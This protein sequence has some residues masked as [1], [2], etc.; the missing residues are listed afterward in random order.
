MYIVKYIINLQTM[1]KQMFHFAKQD[2]AAVQDQNIYYKNI[3]NFL[4]LNVG[5][6]A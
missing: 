6:I 1:L 3:R 2:L 4:Y 5:N